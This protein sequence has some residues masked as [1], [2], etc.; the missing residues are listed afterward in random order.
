MHECLRLSA[1]QNL[2]ISVRRAAQAAISG[3]TDRIA[4]IVATMMKPNNTSSMIYLLPLAY[5]LLDPTRIPSTDPDC[6]VL[7]P[8]EADAT[9]TATYAL[10]A[11]ARTQTIPGDVAADIWSRV[12]LWHQFF[13]AHYRVH[14]E[15]L[16]EWRQCCRTVQ[17]AHWLQHHTHMKPIIKSTPGFYSVVSRAWIAA[18]SVT[19]S[20]QNSAA[21]LFTPVATFIADEDL[22]ST[23]QRLED[24]VGDHG[25][26]SIATLALEHARHSLDLIEDVSQRRTGFHFL[27]N[28]VVFIS[29]I[30]K[31]SHGA[32]HMELPSRMVSQLARQDILWVLVRAIDA[33]I[34]KS[35]GSER[36]PIILQ[37]LSSLKMLFNNEKLYAV[38]STISAS[39]V[40]IVA[41]C[42]REPS[43][44]ET[45]DTLKTFLR[46][47]I[48]SCSIYWGDR[49]GS[50]VVSALD[51]N[52]SA[53]PE[54]SPELRD[55]WTNFDALARDRAAFSESFDSTGVVRMKACDNTLCTTFGPMTVFKRCSGCATLFYCSVQCQAVDWNNG[56][57]TACK[58]H[59]YLLR[60]RPSTNP[61]TS[62]QRA[63]M[64]AILHRDYMHLKLKIYTEAVRTMHLSGDPNAGYFVMF[65]YMRGDAVVDVHSLAL[66][67]ED[68]TWLCE[69]EGEWD[70]IE[71]RAGT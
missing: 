36:K 46:E 17:A 62:R 5:R 65:D 27:F 38:R 8:A 11:V 32:H 26:S 41:A 45:H 54:F 59:I 50:Q 7:T 64:R 66:E 37:S 60:G 20:P 39:L 55:A 34:L 23:P 19:G 24:F 14:E 69:M 56:H 35:T 9:H 22:I 49:A 1:L 43:L 15:Q 6:A 51:I 53:V 61:P 48:P 68:L 25:P 40:G 31:A 57:R 47:H 71:A 58:L 44:T 29:I 28:V 2:P 18:L 67:S 4:W 63:F 70:E 12:W 13:E 30:Q 21:P 10:D 33:A 16:Q 52:D 3:P 42:G